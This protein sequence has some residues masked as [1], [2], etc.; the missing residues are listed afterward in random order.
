M[1]KCKATLYW[2][3][4]KN[5]VEKFQKIQRFLRNRNLVQSVLLT[6]TPKYRW[7]RP[8][9]KRSNIGR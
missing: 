9:F 6:S 5:F 2:Q 1:Q 3:D 4:I 7:N 8:I